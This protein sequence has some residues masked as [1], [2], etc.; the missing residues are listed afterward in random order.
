VIILDRVVATRFSPSLG[1]PFTYDGANDWLAK[2]LG[3]CCAA[4][5]T[6]SPIVFQQTKQQP[7]RRDPLPSEAELTFLQDILHFLT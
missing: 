7:I 4:G 3:R 5:A 1:R 6:E 2:G